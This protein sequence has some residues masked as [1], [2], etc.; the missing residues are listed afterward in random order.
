MAVHVGNRSTTATDHSVHLHLLLKDQPLQPCSVHAQDSVLGIR[1]CVIM[2]FFCWVR[3]YDS[4]A[5]I[6]MRD[7]RFTSFPGLR[8]RLLLL[9]LFFCAGQISSLTTQQTTWL[10]VGVACRHLEVGVGKVVW[11]AVPLLIVF[12]D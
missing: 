7:T 3:D 5:N 10:L 2:F 4:R 6:M 12:D 11:Y 8:V 1:I 9:G